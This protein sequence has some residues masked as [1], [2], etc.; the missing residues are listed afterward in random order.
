MRIRRF[1]RVGDVADALGLSRSRVYQLMEDGTIPHIRLGRSVVIPPDAWERWLAV[2]R[3][4]ALSA[5]KLLG[6]HESTAG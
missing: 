1:L 5:V 2:K 4:Q 3:D 6:T